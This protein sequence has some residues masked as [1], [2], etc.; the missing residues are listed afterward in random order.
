MDIKGGQDE[1]TPLHLACRYNSGSATQLLL[2][3]GISSNARDIK[4]K[5]PL[6]YATRR[7]HDVITKVSV[8]PDRD[9]RSSPR[10]VTVVSKCAARSGPKVRIVCSHATRRRHKV[11]TNNLKVVC[12]VDS[13]I[14]QHSW[15]I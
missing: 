15:T 4:G 11:I 1:T 13:T 7:G 12:L 2:T 6:H 5:T 9:P 8:T 3:R 10:S 14:I